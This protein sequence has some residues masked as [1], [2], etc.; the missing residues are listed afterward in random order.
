MPDGVPANV[1]VRHAARPLTPHGFVELGLP[2]VRRPD[3]ARRLGE[4]GET[5]VAEQLPLVRGEPSDGQP[6]R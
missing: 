6:G 5:Q 2:G 4:R 3:A 1:A